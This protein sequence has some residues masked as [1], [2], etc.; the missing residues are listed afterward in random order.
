[1]AGAGLTR[2]AGLALTLV[3]MVLSICLSQRMGLI[4]ACPAAG[5]AVSAEQQSES[6]SGNEDEQPT[7]G[8]SCDLSGKLLFKS[9]SLQDIPLVGLLL[10]LWPLI[11]PRYFFCFLIKLCFAVRRRRHLLFCV[12]RE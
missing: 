2:R 6:R 12:F 11:P 5:G 9:W 1:M 10:L 7:P 8:Q 4:L 3:L